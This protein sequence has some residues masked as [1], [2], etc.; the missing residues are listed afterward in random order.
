MPG[1]DCAIVAANDKFSRSPSSALDQGELSTQSLLQMTG[2]A[3]HPVA[4]LIKVNY[5]P[6]STANSWVK[7]RNTVA[8]E[9]SG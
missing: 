1:T 9:V 5:Q 3:V 7:C 4:H 2:L 6:N 8:S